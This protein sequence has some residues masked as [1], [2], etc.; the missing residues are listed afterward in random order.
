MSSITV[1]QLYHQY[2]ESISISE[3][4]QL[5][6]VMSQHIAQHAVTQ[7]KH[8]SMMKD[9]HGISEEVYLNCKFFLTYSCISTI[10][11][12]L[13]PKYINQRWM[14]QKAKCS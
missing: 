12:T 3:Q 2:I 5:I 9:F 13:F 4:L 6:A 10:N 7:G 1:E 8:E 14:T 11:L